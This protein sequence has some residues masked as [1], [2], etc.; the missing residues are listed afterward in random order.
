MLR[1]RLTSVR[2]SPPGRRRVLLLALCAVVVAC[3]L[4]AG[5]RAYRGTPEDGAPAVRAA[6][7]PAVTTRYPAPGAAGLGGSGG[8]SAPRAETRRAR[9]PGRNRARQP[10]PSPGVSPGAGTPT[11]RT[12]PGTSGSRADA[13]RVVV[14]LGDSIP[15]GANCPGC[16]TYVDEVGHRY[17]AATSNGAVIYNHAVSGYTTGDVLAQLAD[18]GLQRHLAR[19]DL[20]IL[21]IGANDVDPAL[22]T[23]PRCAD[24]ALAGCFEKTLATIRSELDQI[25]E[26][27]AASLKAGARLAVT[28]YWNVVT[29]GAVGRAEG[30]AWVS[31]SAALTLRANAVIE[32]VTRSRGGT[33]VEVRTAFHGPDGTR[34]ITG[35][36]ADDGDHL[37]AAGH[38]LM[39]EVVMAALR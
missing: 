32:D 17:A 2:A 7:S 35:L 23:D 20:V 26:R 18:A 37:N 15:A 9:D 33:Y 19:A 12:V 14:G 11:G 3:A 21:T 31:G 10:T 13:A 22:L 34:D 1:R 29:D 8:S 27:V 25:E 38:A 28:G 24:A 6:A 16:T 5:L 39:T 4:V 30:P 36:L